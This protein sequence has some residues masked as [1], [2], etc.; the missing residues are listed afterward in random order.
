MAAM[1]AIRSSSGAPGAVHLRRVSLRWL[2]ID[3]LDGPDSLWFYWPMLDTGL[4]VLVIGI[5]MGG[6]GGLFGA[7]WEGARS[8]STLNGGAGRTLRREV[9]ASRIQAI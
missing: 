3:M 8:R 1:G 2:T 5:V 9:A 4:G 6:V 7:G